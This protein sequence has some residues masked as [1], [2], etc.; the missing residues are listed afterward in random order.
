MLFWVMSYVLVFGC[1]SCP[2]SV[3]AP[4]PVFG[5]GSVLEQKR[6]LATTTLTGVAGLWLRKQIHVTTS[7]GNTKQ[8]FAKGQR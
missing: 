3:A 2:F 4:V 7:A 8:F 5:D 1:E 6:K